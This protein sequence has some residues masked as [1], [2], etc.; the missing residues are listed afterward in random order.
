M[1]GIRANALPMVAAR[2]GGP[3]WDFNAAHAGLHGGVF[4]PLH[5]HTYQV[6]LAAYGQPDE[7]GMV[8][9]FG[10]LKQLLR[11][12]LAPLK[13]RTLIAARTPGVTIERPDGNRVRVRGCGADFSL[14][15]SW[16]QLLPIA[17]TSTE[18]L[19]TYLVV[20][21]ER[22]TTSACPAID[23]L[24]LTLAESAE[25]AATVLAVLR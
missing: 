6:T 15:G 20:E 25:C 19:A 14:P 10:V 13:R 7:A 4:E 24:E 9:D 22:L 3:G 23:R 8:V 17:G 11:E 21:L 2:V 12:V 1:T 5:G 18:A 16:V